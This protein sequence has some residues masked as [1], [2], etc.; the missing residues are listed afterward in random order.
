[1]G[2]YGDLGAG[3]TTIVKGISRAFG[4]KSRDITSAS[5][6]IIVEYESD[7]PFFHIDLYR[8]DN[9]S[10]LDNTGIWDYIGCDGVSVVEWAEKL[11]DFLPDNFINVALVI[12]GGSRREVIIEG[13][14]E[15]DWHN[16]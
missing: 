8:I 9:K 10:D 15:E 12:T 7:P 13:I 6:T 5:F 3:K 16:L 2:L 1:V 4:I 11:G 14:N